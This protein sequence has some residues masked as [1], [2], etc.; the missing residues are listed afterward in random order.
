MASLGSSSSS[1]SLCC[2]HAAAGCATS[3][4]SCCSVMYAPG[5]SC[6]HQP[7]SSLQLRA[8]RH[9]GL[10]AVCSVIGRV[11]QVVELSFSREGSVARVLGAARLH[12]CSKLEETDL[13]LVIGVVVMIYFSWATFCITRLPHLLQPY[14]TCCGHAFVDTCVC[15]LPCVLAACPLLRAPVVVSPGPNPHGCGC[16]ISLLGYCVSSCEHDASIL[17]QLCSSA[18]SWAG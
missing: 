9:C 10:A 17:C 7:A 13:A 11:V 4:G 6:M 15:L 16:A 2:K 1:S 5:S 14:E 8:T 12:N 18:A 3:A